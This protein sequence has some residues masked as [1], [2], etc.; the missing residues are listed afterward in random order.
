ML[1]ETQRSAHTL[2]RS[3]GGSAGDIGEKLAFRA[4]V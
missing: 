4:A 3:G 2:R 1:K